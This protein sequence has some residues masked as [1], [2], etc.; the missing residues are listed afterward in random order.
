MPNKGI[1]L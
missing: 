1:I